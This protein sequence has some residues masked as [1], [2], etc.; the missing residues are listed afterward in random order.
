LDLRPW[1]NRVARHPPG[2]EQRG[3]PCWYTRDTID[4]KYPKLGG[5]RVKNSGPASLR[6]QVY[7]TLRRA[8]RKGR[9]GSSP[10]ITERDLAQ[11]LGV[12]RTPVREALV[13][14]MHDGLIASTGRGFTPRKLSRRDVV[15]LYQIRRLLEPAAL[16]S[17]VEHLSTHD[18]RM[19]RQA[20][21]EQ[22]T[23]DAARDAEAFATA[24]ANFRAV[25]LAA[26]PNSQLRALIDQH[27][28]HVQW[29]RQITLHEPKV[30]KKVL[31]GQ[32]NILAALNNAN[33]V[34]AATAMATHVHA[35]EAALAA[36][37]E[38]TDSGRTAA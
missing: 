36:V 32:R 3:L 8:L 37:L 26:V 20:L 23:A 31:A 33:A 12:S 13:L 11:E 35:A 10:T 17:T 14:L 24:N 1:K 4:V 18:L 9:L 34:A 21:K 29:L 2:L 7:Q 22:E 16:A 6:E 15:E 27:G 5:R 30:R 28:D 38:Q 25:W 19:L